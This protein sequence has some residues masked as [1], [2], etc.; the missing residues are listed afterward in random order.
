MTHDAA[1]LAAALEIKGLTF[2]W[3]R[4]E[5]VLDIPDLHIG[6]GE[7]VFLKGASGSGKS[8]LLSLI[9]GIA[10]PQTGTVDVL[11]A[12]LSTLSAA[13]R[14]RF[15][16]DHLGIIFQ[17]FNLLPYLSLVDNVLLPCRF[18]PARADKA[19]ARGGSLKT[20]AMD[21][22][23]RLGLEE[24]AKSHRPVT[25]LSVGQQQRVAA[26]RALIGGPGLILADE[27][28]SALDEGAQLAFLSTLMDEAKASGAA[29]LFVSHDPRMQPRFDRVLDLAEI[30][31]AASVG[32]AA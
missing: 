6:A 7:H 31:R 23:A 24:I 19:K 11:G 32:A 1:A 20:A 2:A 25:T 22:L 18:S 13:K 4:G 30:N 10:T 28:T 16:G 21:L 27:P 26:A 15:R 3:T 12:P 14:D 9:A 5:P 17:Q 29:L 8:T